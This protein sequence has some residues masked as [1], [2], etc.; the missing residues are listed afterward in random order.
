MENLGINTA[1]LLPSWPTLFAI[2]SYKYPGFGRELYNVHSLYCFVAIMD[3]LP[4]EI[5]F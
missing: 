1:L 3:F 2:I 5:I 4:E